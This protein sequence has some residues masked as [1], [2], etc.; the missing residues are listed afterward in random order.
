[1]YLISNIK[2]LVE[3]FLKYRVNMILIYLILCHVVH[4]GI[5]AGLNIERFIFPVCG[6]PH[7]SSTADWM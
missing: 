3:Y 6:G 4:N 1:M 2:L 5:Y 7:Q